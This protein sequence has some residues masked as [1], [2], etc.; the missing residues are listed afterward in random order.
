M[1]MKKDMSMVLGLIVIVLA[2][3]LGYMVWQKNQEQESMEPVV[4]T[5]AETV[6]AGSTGG[7]ASS[8]VPAANPGPL[9]FE[10]ALEIYSANGYRFEFASCHGRPGS[11][12]MKVGTKFMLDN[13]DPLAHTFVA[14]SSTYHI[15]PYG[16]AIATAKDLGT[17]NITCD[18]GGAA[19][20][21]VQK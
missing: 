2:V 10:Q 3:L 6:P 8:S 15:G 18:G 1:K 19:Q 21:V 7:D 13:R 11:L 20:V 5:P 4:E 9:T 16:F 12:S 17:Y 14:G